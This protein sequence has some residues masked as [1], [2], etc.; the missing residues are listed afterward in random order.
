LI[1]LGYQRP[2]AEK[3]VEKVLQAQ[4]DARF[5]AALKHVLRSLMKS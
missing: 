2:V 1:N 5:E 4:P 3:A